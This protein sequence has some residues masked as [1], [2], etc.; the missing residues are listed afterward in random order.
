[1]LLGVVKT[2]SDQINVTGSG[3]EY[4][5]DWDNISYNPYDIFTNNAI[6]LT[7]GPRYFLLSLLIKLGGLGP[8]NTLLEIWG[9][10]SDGDFLIWRGNPSYIISNN[11]FNL[12]LTQGFILN[13]SE[14]PEYSFNINVM[15]NGGIS[16]SADVLQG[17]E[18]QIISLG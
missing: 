17:S 1:M 18:M 3:T 12:N 7:N 11:T 13:Q 6:T 10:A 4:T 2:S 9:N 15:V 5:I 8:L 16:N 14:N